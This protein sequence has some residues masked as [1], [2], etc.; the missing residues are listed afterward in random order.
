MSGGFLV[1]GRPKVDLVVLA[2]LVVEY[3]LAIA[4]LINTLIA[5]SVPDM[6]RGELKITAFLGVSCPA[7]FDSSSPPART[8][9]GTL[10]PMG[11]VGAVVCTYGPQPGGGAAPLAESKRPRSTVELVVTLNNLPTGPLTPTPLADTLGP[12]S[13]GQRLQSYVII[14]VYLVEDRRVS[15]QGYTDC[16]LVARDGDVRTDAQLLIPKLW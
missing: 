8:R 2:A 16:G 9:V 15:I 6:S 7:T 12:T 5:Q 10:V 3:A 1:K 14:F 11:L 13:C 4:C